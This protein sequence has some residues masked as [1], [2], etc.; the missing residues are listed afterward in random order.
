M[1]KSEIWSW[2]GKTPI[3]VQLGELRPG[4]TPACSRF[5]MVPVVLEFKE[6]Y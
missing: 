3:N 4:E 1:K 5:A 6:P 2:A